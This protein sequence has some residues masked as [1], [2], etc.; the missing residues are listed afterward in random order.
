VNTLLY[1]F[2]LKFNLLFEILRG[3][4]TCS[5]FK[6]SVTEFI[7]NPSAKKSFFIFFSLMTS[8]YN[9]YFR[10]VRK[11]N[12]PQMEMRIYFMA[13]KKRN[14]LARVNSIF[15][16][17]KSKVNSTNTDVVRRWLK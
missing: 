11:A 8:A 17:D 9:F 7:N 4:E 2:I 10:Q 5:V 3:V 16:H 14:P 13:A 1:F 15:L 12:F 6:M